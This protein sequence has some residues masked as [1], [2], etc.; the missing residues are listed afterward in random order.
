[1]VGGGG[2]WGHDPPFT[3]WSPHCPPHCDAV[4]LPPSPVEMKVCPNLWSP[5]IKTVTPLEM[6]LRGKSV[7]SLCDGSTD[8]SFMVDPLSYFSFHAVLHDWCNKGRDMCY[9]GMVHIEEP[10]LLIGKSSPFG[11]S[12]FPLA[13]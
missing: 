11:G 6:Y 4:L 2:G 8:R 9:P 10:L 7:R 3:P 13:I 5:K 12:G 1:M